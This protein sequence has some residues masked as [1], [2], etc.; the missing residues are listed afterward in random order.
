MGGN[1]HRVRQHKVCSPVSIQSCR[2]SVCTLSHGNGRVEVKCLNQD[3]EIPLEAGKA[4]GIVFR[5][6]YLVI[7]VEVT[8]LIF[9]SLS[10]WDGP[11][12][13]LWII[14]GVEFRNNLAILQGS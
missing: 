4:R 2:A 11:A 8:K 3:G 14:P 5:N 6:S 1:H 9:Q 10:V 12:L 7:T 13:L